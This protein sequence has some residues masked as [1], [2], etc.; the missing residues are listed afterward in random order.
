MI[1]K[2]TQGGVQ[3]DKPRTKKG[4]GAK[5]KMLILVGNLQS[6]PR[7]GNPVGNMLGAQVILDLILESLSALGDVEGKI[8]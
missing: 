5:L 4:A 1:S 3:D 6:K 8:G 2:I 7:A